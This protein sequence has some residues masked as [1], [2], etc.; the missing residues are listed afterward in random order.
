MATLEGL[1]P[2]Q[3]PLSAVISFHLLTNQTDLMEK[4]LVPIDFSD[5]SENALNY[6]VAIAQRFDY[7]IVLFHTTPLPVG[8]VDL[9]QTP[10]D[11]N[12]QADIDKASKE[13]LQEWVVSAKQKADKELHFSVRTSMGDLIPSIKI[14]VE[15]EDVE[16]IVTSTRGADGALIEWMGTN[17][18]DLVAE[19][20]IPILVVPEKAT[21]RGFKEILY[22]TNFEVGDQSNLRDT[23]AFAKAF[24]AKVD[25]VHVDVDDERPE[26]DVELFENDVRPFEAP[27]TV[28][29][30]QVKAKEI[31]NGINKLAKDNN[32]DL[33]AIVRPMRGFWDELFHQ[34][35]SKKLALHS[36]RPLLVLRP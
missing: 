30:W 19:T 2:A 15:E 35:I 20:Q 3:S 34:S 8:A 28:R 22:A 5:H 18:S 26:N 29:F 9:A 17:S 21:F 14:Y 7:E 13:R 36:E 32:S 11:M 24:D 27:K 12:W 23:M 6:A 16:L 33:I 10:V 25:V 1:D 4:I 31:E